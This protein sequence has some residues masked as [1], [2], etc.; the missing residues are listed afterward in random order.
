MNSNNNEIYVII[1][2]NLKRFRKEMKLSQ[3][4]LANKCDKVDRAKISDIENIKEDFMLSTIL[5]ISNALGKTL[6]EMISRQNED[7][8]MND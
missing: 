8:K 1:G 7:A 5:D 3:Q 2:T 6:K 4:D